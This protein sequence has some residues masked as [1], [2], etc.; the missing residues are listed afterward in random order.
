MYDGDGNQVKVTVGSGLS[1]TTVY[2]GNGG[3]QIDVPL[4]DG[5][6]IVYIGNYYEEEGNTTRTYYYHNGQPLAALK[7][8]RVE[9]PALAP[10]RS[11]ARTGRKGAREWHAVLATHRSAGQHGSGG[12]RERGG[13]RG[14]AVA[15]SLP[16]AERRGPGLRRHAR[17]HRH[18]AHQVRLH[19]AAGR[20]R[21]GAVLPQSQ[22]VVCSLPEVQRRGRPHAAPLSRSIP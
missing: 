2:V 13:D 9:T 16:E 18:H 12:G 8:W 7:T 4:G 19:R 14:A 21:H 6:T 10:R 17:H 22:M 15:R 5:L 1:S 20:V 11:A 3:G